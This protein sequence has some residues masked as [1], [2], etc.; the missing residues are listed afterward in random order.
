MSTQG[1]SNTSSSSPSSRN[2]NLLA[3]KSA[4]GLGGSTGSGR[5][6]DAATVWT[7]PGRGSESAYSRSRSAATTSGSSSPRRATAAAPSS[8]GR[9]PLLDDSGSSSRTGRSSISSRGG[10]GGEKYSSSH[11]LSDAARSEVRRCREGSSVGDYSAKEGKLSRSS[12]TAPSV[13]GGRLTPSSPPSQPTFPTSKTHQRDS[14]SSASSAAS[15]SL[16]RVRTNNATSN[17]GDAGTLEEGSEVESLT[18]GRK[19]VNSTDGNFASS[20][21]FGKSS[22]TFNS[23]YEK[24]K[25]FYGEGEKGSNLKD[26]AHVGARGTGVRRKR[27]GDGRE[28]LVSMQIDEEYYAVDENWCV[29]PIDGQCTV[30]GAIRRDAFAPDGDHA[31]SARGAHDPA[32]RRRERFL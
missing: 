10:G 2:K 22:S 29:C 7:S 19:V 31:D 11:A 20:S 18:G 4:L 14:S 24:K 32:I 6:G 13:R 8:H 26:E 3:A 27:F 17:I 12:F 25:I 5:S 15:S 21:D 23:Y 9:V 30:V 16:A 28:S 1:N